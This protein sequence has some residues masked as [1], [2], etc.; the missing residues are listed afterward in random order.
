MHRQRAQSAIGR[1]CG[2]ISLLMM[3]FPHAARYRLVGG[4]TGRDAALGKNVDGPVLAREATD[5]LDPD[6]TSLIK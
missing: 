2:E 4:E 1:L 3:S 6:S 5:A